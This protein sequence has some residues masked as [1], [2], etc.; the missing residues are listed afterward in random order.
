M[1]TSG[2]LT[3]NACNFMFKRPA[4]KQINK[5]FIF[6]KKA[7]NIILILLFTFLTLKYLKLKF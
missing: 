7:K 4:T 2:K 3:L 6:C 5:T 1:F